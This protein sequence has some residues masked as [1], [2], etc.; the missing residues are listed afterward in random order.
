M[1][2][3]LNGGSLE[4][5]SADAIG[6]G[7]FADREWGPGAEAVLGAVD[8][9]ALLDAHSFSGELGQTV[10]APTSGP[11]GLVIL[12]GLGSD[13]DHEGL[14]RAS[15]CFARAAQ[16]IR[17]VA[18]TLHLVELDGAGA[19]VAEGFSLGAYVFDRYKADQ[20]DAD[21][22][23][24]FLGGDVPQADLDHAV[25]VSDAVILARDLVNE[26]ALDMSPEA[27]SDL[28][29]RLADELGMDTDLWVGDEVVAEGF[30]GLAGVNA[31][32]DRPARMLRLRYRHPDADTTVAFVGKG[33][34]FDS[35]GLSIKSEEHMRT[36]KT[37]MGGAAAVLAGVTAVA[38]LGL[39]VNIDAIMPLT[40][41]LSGGSATRP[42]D[43]LRARNGTTMEVLNT[44]AEGRL[45]LADGLSLAAEVD[46]DLIV[47]FATLTGAA[48][49][50]LGRTVAGVFSNDDGVAEYLV[51]SATTAGEGSWH[52]PMPAELRSD[53]DSDVADIKN[54]GKTRQGGAITAAFF[55]AEFVGDHKWGHFDIAGP[56][57]TTEEEHY[58]R[59]G[60]TGYGVRTIVAICEGI[61]A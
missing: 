26:P 35:G 20:I 55:L 27:F 54:V 44:D 32:A 8:L 15:G 37:D 56:A 14:R 60:A 21:A 28:A 39:S 23:F 13:L 36:M 45:V 12:V 43:V 11:F 51:N 4:D 16:G 38:M 53:I 40:E 2:E 17:S 24:L 57:W 30:G 34:M 25:I 22:T 9:T 1:I 58:Q 19:A 50:A 31:G 6:V 33:I 10:I 52:M 42:G 7:V 29:E 41:N 59:K 61:V 48:A 46:P 49:V 5:G 47:D 3:F 18:T